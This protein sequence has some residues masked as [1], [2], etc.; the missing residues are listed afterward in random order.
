MS[1]KE[2]SL[3]WKILIGLLCG[4]FWGLIAP[5][6]GLE[7]WTSDWIA[8]VGD[9]FVRFLKLIA[10]PLVVT[11][12]VLGIAQVDDRGHLAGMGFRTIGFYLLTTTLAIVVGLA[13]ASWVQPGTA[14]P[15]EL[16]EELSTRYQVQTGVDGAENSNF[17]NR[18]WM[19]FIADL[20]PENVISALGANDQMLQVVLLALLFGL[21]LLHLSP[22]RS[23]PVIDLIQGIQEVLT[24]FVSWIMKI[25]PY[26]VFALMAHVLVEISDESGGQV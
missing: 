2:S 9:L 7:A 8:P 16:R 10:I 19:Q 22:D 25:A 4:V 20:V 17:E 15:T 12:L 13:V 18:S 14:L 1:Q 24:L 23:R 3:H 6:M 26:G 5:S 11:S 21:A